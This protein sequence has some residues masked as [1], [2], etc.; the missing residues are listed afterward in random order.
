MKKNVLK[1]EPQQILNDPL[2]NKGSGFTDDEREELGLHGLLPY[3]V[4]TIE[5]QVVRRYDNFLAK[6]DPLA[7]YTFLSA[8]QSRNEILFFRLVI[9]HLEEMLPLIYTP[10]VGEASLHY[11]FIYRESRGLY[12]SYPLRNKMEK[13]FSHLAKKEIDIV[14]VTDGERILGLGD[15]GIGGMAI[16]QGKLALYTLFAGIH[17][18]RTLAIHLDVGTNNPDLLNDPL[19]LGWSH[20]RIRGKEYEK[21]VA[22]FVKALKRHYPN[23][24]LQWED[25]GRENAQPLLDKYRDQIA[26]FNDDIQGTAA[27]VLAGIIAATKATKKKLKDQKIVL[28][29]A[30]SAGL[31]ICEMLVR[32]MMDEGASEKNARSQFYLIDIGGLIHADLKEATSA[33]KKFARPLEEIKRWKVNDPKKIT[34]LEVVKNAKPDVLIG[35]S[36]QGG[37]FTEEIVREMAKTCVRPIIFPLSN[38]TSKSEAHPKDL[39]KWTQGKAIVAT[40]SP[41]EKVSQCNNVYIFPGVGLGVIISRAKK[42][43]DR[44]F[45]TAANILAEHSPL[46]KNEKGTLF[47]SFQALRDVSSEIAVGVA[48]VAQKEKVGEKVTLEKLK[49]RLKENVWFP[50]YPIYTRKNP[51][52]V[53]TPRPPRNTERRK[54]LK[55]TKNRAAHDFLGV[56]RRPVF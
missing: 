16:P 23:A 28:L 1:L 40:G 46:L 12:L 27:T 5:E 30:G 34:L 3:H 53:K 52:R 6:K 41:F 43:T 37:A 15:L 17:P 2:L 44:M 7:R 47:P 55:K 14:V 22:S 8:L 39:H 36:T 4:S 56:S 50:D 51:R 29:G 38:P 9:E 45:L 18:A 19:Y 11:S 24:L 10:T 35:V 32:A 31:G 49:K 42:V 26:S 21:F 25:F 54:T 13:I 20:K 33:Q 48:L